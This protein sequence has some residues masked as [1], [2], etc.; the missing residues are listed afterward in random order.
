MNYL[1]HLGHPAHFHLFKYVI[2]KLELNNHR[3][4]IIIK[5]KD[6]LEKLLIEA[7]FNYSNYLPEGQ[8][9]SKS[10]MITSII[11]RELKMLIHCQDIRYDLMIGTSTEV[12][13]MGKMLGIKSICV[14]EDDADA[15]PLFAKYSYPFAT[16]ILTPAS[17]NSGK[18]DCKAIK[19]NSFHEL[20]YL[21]PQY[22]KP[23]SSYLNFYGIKRPYYIIRFS[24]L[25]AHHDVG[26]KGIPAGLAKEII[27][28]LEPCGNV[29]I[30][31]E[32][33]LN[34]CF[35]KYCL[36]IN[37]LD[38]HQVLAQADLYIGD[39]QTMTAECAVLGTP[40][41]RFNDFVGKLGYLEELEHKYGLTYGIKTNE[42][43]KLLNKIDE[44]LLLPDAKAE[45]EMKKQRMLSD[46]ID[47]TD[48][49]TWFIASYPSSRTIMR[50]NPEYQYNFKIRI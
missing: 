14:N 40:A 15:I 35:G 28:K 31:S 12:T 50:S 49:L 30:T 32:K 29:Y 21:A 48:F 37:P 39:S 38:M 34:G 13:H 22:F 36:N 8:K 23:D 43:E 9:N 5:K 17:C 11:K 18:W 41:L 25:D 3:V 6:V 24:G 44:V 27:R 45:W 20:A 42:P 33:E 4:T 10:G 46:K 1:F 7:G 19:Y 47:T 16:E 26:K 2:K